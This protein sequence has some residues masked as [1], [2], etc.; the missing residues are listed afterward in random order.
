MTFLDATYKTSQYALPLFFVAVKTN[1][2]YS[3]VA[4]F[5]VQSETREVIVKGLKL[6]SEW[7]Q[8]IN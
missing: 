1:M 4:Q 2:G 6:I 3:V 7:M 5:V 8:K